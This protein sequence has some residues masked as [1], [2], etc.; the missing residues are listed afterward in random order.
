MNQ[1]LHDMELGIE[2]WQAALKAMKYRG[3]IT[4]H[5]SDGSDFKIE[6]R[7]I[8]TLKAYLEE[9]EKEA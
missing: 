4:L 1:N 2:K 9:L 6:K 3:S 7:Q 8:M 5:T